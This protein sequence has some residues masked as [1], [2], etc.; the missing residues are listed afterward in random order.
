MRYLIKFSKESEIKFVAHLDLMRTIQRMMKRSGLPVMYSQGFNPHIVLSLAQPLAVGVYSEGDYMD[1]SFTTFVPEN[2]IKEA[3]NRC[4]PTGIKIHEVVNIKEE[5][6]KRVF[7]GMAEVDA[8]KYLIRIKYKDISTLKGE[9]DSL[10]KK[11]SWTLIK[12]S[13][14]AEKE[15]D[16]K[17][18][19]KDFEFRIIEGVLIID[20][21]VSCGSSENLSAELLANYIKSN[22]S[23][24]DLEAFVDVKRKEMYAYEGGKL[25]PLYKYAKM[26]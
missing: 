4:A 14:K 13:K 3:L 20:T 1:A 21:I 23:N 10:L 2:E 9:I 15:V 24:C 8:A 11:K 5:E 18:M 17:P 25:I 6:N 19:I 26:R 7:R 22:T 12:K 16:I